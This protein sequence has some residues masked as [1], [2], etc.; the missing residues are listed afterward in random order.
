MV[1]LGDVIREAKSGFASG[2]NSSQGVLQVRM[3]NV[4]T[5]GNLDFREPRRVPASE[6]V[7]SAFGLR[8]GDVLFNNTNSPE[9]VG[10]SAVFFGHPEPV[11]FSN[12]FT[13]LRTVEGRLDPSFLRRWLVRQWE[14]QV[15]RGLC[16]RW[17]N[18]AAV[19]KE[20]LL[21]LKIPLPRLPE[22]QRIAA[23]LDKAY[24][25]RRK[26]QETIALTEELLR[27]TFLEM[28][29]DP[30][31]NPKR[32]PTKPICEIATVTTGNTPPRENP[33]YYGDSIEWIKS[34]NINTRHHLVT[35]ATEGLSAEG[36]A[37][38]RVAPVDSTLITCIAG[39]R[40]CIGNAAL[41]DRE[42][43]FN[44]Q[45]SA[46]TANEDVDPYFLYVQVLLAKRLIQTAS[47]N[48]MKGM[49]SKGR[50]EDVELIVPPEQ[51]Q[52][53]FGDCFRTLLGLTKKATCFYEESEQLFGSL[54]QR[55]FRGEL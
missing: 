41:T 2:E 53:Q 20:A 1:P 9:L 35:K 40:D 10:K 29:G 47:T 32:W 26:R 5:E 23:I 17:V 51:L 12:H 31:T 11:V 34:D 39:S 15:F 3:N 21:S 28:F 27:S 6:A 52:R 16:T 7:I 13:R 18:Q 42:V 14:K 30:V 44:Q 22:Q 46:L 24:A 55:A 25:I 49:V 8:P 33:A 50:L 54:V 19:R 45:I 38:G 48:S 4:D 37:V 43:A 36:R